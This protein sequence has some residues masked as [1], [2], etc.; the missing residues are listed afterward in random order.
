LKKDF[1][2]AKELTKLRVR[3]ETAGGRVTRLYRYYEVEKGVWA[4][5]D[6]TEEQLAELGVD[7][8]LGHLDE[9]PEGSDRGGYVPFVL[10]THTWKLEGTDREY[11]YRVYFDEGAGE[12]F[13]S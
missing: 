2:L 3:V 9:H 10:S 4:E 8:E 12:W 7:P 13:P 5:E 11:Q 6:L 1:E